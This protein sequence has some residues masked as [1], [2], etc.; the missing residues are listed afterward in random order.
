MET[1]N[2]VM[3][4]RVTL[5]S[6][7]LQGPRRQGERLRPHDPAR[8]ATSRAAHSRGLSP[9]TSLSMRLIAVYLRVTQQPKMATAERARRRMTEPPRP[10]QAPAR[11]RRRHEVTHRAV[12]GFD[13]WTVT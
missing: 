11:I 10:S 3:P 1:V 9:M 12:E 4:A 8:P 5:K 13:C 7:Q 2:A 6:A